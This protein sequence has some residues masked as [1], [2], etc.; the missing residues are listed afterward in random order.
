[1]RI[2]DRYTIT[3]PLVKLDE[4]AHAL[5]GLDL[6]EPANNGLGTHPT[7]GI[8]QAHPTALTDAQFAA[9]VAIPGVKSYGPEH[10]KTRALG[11]AKLHQIEELDLQGE[12]GEKP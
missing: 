1:M 10:T 11:Y 6:Y 5:G 2:E 3:F 8:I 7:H 12:V 4:V 9:V